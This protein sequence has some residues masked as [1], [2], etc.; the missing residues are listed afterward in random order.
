VRAAMGQTATPVVRFEGDPEVVVGVPL[1]DKELLKALRQVILVSV[2]QA[3][4]HIAIFEVALLRGDLSGRNEESSDSVWSGI[5]QLAIKA[6]VPGIGYSGA[7]YGHH[8]LVLL[9]SGSSLFVVAAAVMSLFRL[10]VLL[11]PSSLADCI[12][13]P[14]DARK[15]CEIMA[16]GGVEKDTIITDLVVTMAL[17]CLGCLC[18]RSLYWALRPRAIGTSS[19]TSWERL[20]PLMGEVIVQGDG[21]AA[22]QVNGGDGGVSITS[23]SDSSTENA[24]AG[25]EEAVANAPQIVAGERD[26]QEPPA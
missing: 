26:P 23:V 9:F 20:V 14:T 24:D 25:D 12:D 3:A 21:S 11:Q 2:L 5:S 10:L 15:M 1:Q 18:G 8:V 7:V 17:S 19:L 22:T 4:W 13:E 16:R 6:S